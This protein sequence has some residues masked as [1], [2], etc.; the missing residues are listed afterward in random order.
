[1]FQDER[2]SYGF[3]TTWVWVINDR[4]FIF[5]WT[6]PLIPNIHNKT[7]IHIQ[8]KTKCPQQKSTSFITADLSWAMSNVSL[9]GLPEC[10]H[11]CCCFFSL[12][13]SL[14]IPLLAGVPVA[15]RACSKYV[16][17][18]NAGTLGILISGWGGGAQWRHMCL[19]CL[20]VIWLYDRPSVRISS[21]LFMGTGAMEHH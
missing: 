6:I 2:R 11:S 17:E 1:M 13:L 21:I 18:C 9:F 20:W 10:L 5:G 12:C 3:G 4:I 19:M 15:G 7:I 14:L 16:T 8:S